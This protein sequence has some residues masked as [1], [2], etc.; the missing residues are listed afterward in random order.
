[1]AITL[2]LASS[3]TTF[4]PSGRPRRAGSSPKQL[5]RMRLELIN[6]VGGLLVLGVPGRVVHSSVVGNIVYF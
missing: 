1:M 5:D 3:R 2:S 6:Y 4:W